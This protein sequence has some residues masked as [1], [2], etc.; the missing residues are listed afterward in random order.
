MPFLA[1]RI[2]EKLIVTPCYASLA[3][4]LEVAA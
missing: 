3:E 4:N 1:A 2:S